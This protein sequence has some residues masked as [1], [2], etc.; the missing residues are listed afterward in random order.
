METGRQGGGGE[1]IGRG[2]RQG[3][4]EQG[5]Q[6]PHSC[7]STNLPPP[8]VPCSRRTTRHT[9]R[10]NHHTNHH[11][12][13]S[14]RHIKCHTNRTNRHTN[15]TNRHTKR[16]TNWPPPPSLPCRSCPTSSTL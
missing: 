10:T 16:H 14:N 1:V 12:N 13:R 11:T 8:S 2:G 15:R 9:N 4:G 5:L 3:G 6:L 7:T